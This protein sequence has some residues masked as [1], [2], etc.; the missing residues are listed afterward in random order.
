[1]AKHTAI[2]LMAILRGEKLIQFGSIVKTIS[3][4]VSG[5]V[6]MGDIWVITL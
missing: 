6:R 5:Q 3:G 1:M 4:F 2:F